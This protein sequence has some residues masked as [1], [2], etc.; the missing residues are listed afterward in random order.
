MAEVVRIY[1]HILG[2]IN[3]TFLTLIP[4]KSN[5]LFLSDYMPNSLCNYVYKMMS[6]LLTNRIN[7]IVSPYVSLEKF[8]FLCNRRI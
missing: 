8:G 6:K 3:S 2:A 5:S 4:K 1:G 7:K